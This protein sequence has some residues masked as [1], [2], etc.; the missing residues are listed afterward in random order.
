MRPLIHTDA[1]SLM[2]RGVMQTSALKTP[3]EAALFVL[4]ARSKSSLVENRYIRLIRLSVSA[5]LR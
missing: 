1:I 3:A 2:R 5:N 4:T